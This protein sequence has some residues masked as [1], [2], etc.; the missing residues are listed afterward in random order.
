MTEGYVVRFVRRDK[1]PNEEYFYPAYEDAAHHLNLF[2]EDDSNLYDRIE[3][4]DIN[5]VVLLALVF[6]QE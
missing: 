3:L 5:D 4:V 2:Q 6:T 1:K